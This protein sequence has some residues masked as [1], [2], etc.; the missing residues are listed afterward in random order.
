MIP[1]TGNYIRHKEDEQSGFTYYS[2][3][4]CPLMS[5]DFYT[6]DDELCAVLSST[7]Q[8]LDIFLIRYYYRKSW[9][10]G[11]RNMSRAKI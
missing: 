7:H 10:S 5:G 9:R 11:H 1:D 2:F 3:T 8:N 6:M 4:P